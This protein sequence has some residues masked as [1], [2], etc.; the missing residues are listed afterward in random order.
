MIQV[1][2]FSGGKDSTAMV[3]AMLERGEQIDAVH[4]FDTSWEFPA[5][6]DH[7]ELFERK[8]GLTVTRLKPPR[9]FDFWMYERPIICRN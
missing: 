9:P 6:Y 5:M 4:W 2:S 3:H 1:C 7:V 8:T